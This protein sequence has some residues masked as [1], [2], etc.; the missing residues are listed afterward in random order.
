M[1]WSNYMII[2]GSILYI[3]I[4]MGCLSLCKASAKENN[5]KY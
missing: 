4:T 2:I 1:Y 5:Y 3:L